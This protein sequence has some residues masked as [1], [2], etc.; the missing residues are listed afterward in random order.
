MCQ[1]VQLTGRNGLQ[2]IRRVRGHLAAVTDMVGK[3]CA[4]SRRQFFRLACA[5]KHEVFSLRGQRAYGISG[6]RRIAFDQNALLQHIAAVQRGRALLHQCRKRRTAAGCALAP[7][8][9]RN[10]LP[11]RRNGAVKILQEQLFLCRARV[12]AQIYK[13]D[14][15][16]LQQPPCSKLLRSQAQGCVPPAA[17]PAVKIDHISGVFAP[18]R[19]QCGAPKC[20]HQAFQQLM[21]AGHLLCQLFAYPLPG[22]LVGYFRFRFLG[23]SL[24]RSLYQAVGLHLTRKLGCFLLQ[25]RPH[26][27]H[28]AVHL[29]CR[30]RLHSLWLRHARAEKIIKK[31]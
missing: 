29:I 11:G 14:L 2:G 21:L 7:A 24:R 1:A 15:R 4:E 13:G 28:L 17:R 12:Q 20:A 8:V 3:A 25:K 19:Q 26:L 31:I 22:I 16:T 30:V 6:Q 5:Q 18:R 23:R 27:L 10:D 9:K